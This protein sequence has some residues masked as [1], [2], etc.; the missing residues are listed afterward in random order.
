MDYYKV[1][2]FL[3]RKGYHKDLKNHGIKYVDYI[4]DNYKFSS[5]LEIGCSQGMAVKKFI[6]KGIEGYGVDVSTTAIQESK[7]IGLSTCQVATAVELPFEDNKFDAV[8]SCDVLE[9]LI[10]ED[11][12]QAIK[13]IKRVSKKYLFLK[14]AYGKEINMTWTNLLKKES[15]FKDIGNL[16]QTIRNRDWW[17]SRIEDDQWGFIESSFLKMLVFKKKGYN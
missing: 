12:E 7:T 4:T 14:I 17:F 15:E 6:E 5:L 13:E 16:H 1:Y 9:H 11:A 10:P 8:F 2:D 3:Y